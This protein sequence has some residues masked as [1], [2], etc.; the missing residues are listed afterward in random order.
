MN[1]SFAEYTPFC[2]GLRA[3]VACVMLACIG[4]GT[5]ATLADELPLWAKRMD[6]KT[7]GADERRLSDEHVKATIHVR[8]GARHAGADGTERRPFPSIRAGLRA[9]SVTLAEGTPTKLKIGPGTYRESAGV[10]DTRDGLV[11]STL[12]IIEGAG[13][14]KTIFT[15]A[16]VVKAEDWV[17]VGQGV[18]AIPWE[19]NFGHRS[20]DW[21]P[22][23]YLGHRSEMLFVDD[24]LAKQV[25]VEAWSVRREGKL[26]MGSNSR[27]VYSRH[28]VRDPREVLTPGTFGV[29][30]SEDSAPWSD[31][32]YFRPVKTEDLRTARIEVS[33]R[34]NLLRVDGGKEHLVIRGMT[35]T[36]A[37]SQRQGGV[38]GPVFLRGKYEQV[39]IEDCAFTWNNFTGL[40]L[41]SID[42]L[43]IR[44]SRFDY[45]G[46][47]GINMGPNRYT[48][49]EGNSTSFNNWRGHWGNYNS[50]A[51]GGI[52]FHDTEFNI[53]RDHTAIGNLCPGIWYDIQCEHI[54]VENLVSAYNQRGLFFEIGNGPY[55]VDKS[56]VAHAQKS[57]VRTLITGP[58]TFKNSIIYNNSDMTE[59]DDQ[60][61]LPALAVVYHPREHSWHKTQR[62]VRPGL[63]LY[64]NNLIVGGPDL[65]MLVMIQPGHHANEHAYAFR[66]IGEGNRLFQAGRPNGEPHFGHVHITHD[67]HWRKQ[68]GGYDAFRSW[69]EQTQG[70]SDAVT[71]DPRFVDP[72]RLDFTVARNSPVADD[73]DLPL[74]AIDPTWYDQVRRFMA[75]SAWEVFADELGYEVSARED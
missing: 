41:N 4:I 36:R 2:R 47:G 33:T 62:L 60:T 13:A 29:A 69:L 22:E 14:D 30:E 24:Y 32:L 23:G 73:D 52:K 66:Y 19:H 10:L 53:L 7:A 58:V 56:I 46:D 8:S 38:I 63:N 72:N 55:Y 64:Q 25:L 35:F 61:P 12:L 57:A 68:D 40:R 44:N 65:K 16:D 34:G 9:A 45:N 21:G 20:P 26:Q 71:Q 42:Y 1:R 31:R 6:E 3:L 5:A 39:L 17:D 70:S 28:G 67:G 75:W 50:W 15:G 74:R 37:A 18:Y 48:L 51:M 11:R 59:G 49:F 43:T 27:L 54:V